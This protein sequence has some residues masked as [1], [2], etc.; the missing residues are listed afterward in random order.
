MR[1]SGTQDP[2]GLRR[3]ARGLV[4]ILIAHDLDA[5][6]AEALTV[7]AAHLPAGVELSPEATSELPEFVR[8]RLE[9]RLR[10]DGLRPDAV[11]AVLAA[12]PANPARAA[13]LA[14]VLDAAASTPT[15]EDTL[16]AY[17]RCARIVRGATGGT[18]VDPDL[19]AD[20]HEQRLHDAVEDVTADLDRTD[21]EAVLEALTTLTPVINDYFDHVL[22]MDTDEVVRS[23][24]LALIRRIADLP[25]E[26]ADLSQMEG[27]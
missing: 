19:F 10:E 21:P 11:A 2:Y 18:E 6:L 23:N 22:V 13:R 20:A 8:R 25:D 5:D 26:V 3:A 1:P 15:W 9:V 24:R 17:A 12:V 4:S 14:P 16:T 7:T 27:F